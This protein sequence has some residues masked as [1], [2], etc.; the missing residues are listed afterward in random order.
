M[1]IQ[2]SEKIIV[3][4]NENNAIEIVL[5]ICGGLMREAK[6]PTIRENADIVIGALYNLIDFVEEES[7]NE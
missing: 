1:I 4:K 3:S 2:R 5:N 7:E 6:C